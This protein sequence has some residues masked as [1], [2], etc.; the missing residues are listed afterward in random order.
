VVWTVGDDRRT[1]VR[2]NT[3]LMYDQALLASYEQALINDGTNTRAAATFQPL[4]PGAPAFPAVLSAGAGA[5]PNTLTTV[6]RD[7]RVASNWQN[8]VQIERQLTDRLA[9][10]VGGSYAR[11]NN[12]PVISNINLI[13]PTGQLSDGRN[14]Y[15]TAVNA[16]T[17]RDPR[18]NSILEVQSLGESTYRALTAQLTGRNLWGGVQFDLAYTLAKTEDNAPITTVLSVQGDP[19]GRSNPDDLDFD[20][21]PNALD[22]RHTFSGSVV[23]RPTI[24]GGNA[25][26]RAIVNGTVVGLAMQFASGVPIYLRSASEINN[27]G[28]TTADRPVGVGRNA[29]NLPARYNTDLRLSRQVGVGGTRKIEV[30]AE[31][32]NLFNTVQWSGVQ[33]PAIA[34]NAATGVATGPIPTSGDQLIPNAGYEQRQLQIGFRFVF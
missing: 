12:L 2:A 21:G 23:A 19:G 9:A 8:N 11:G 33:N 20:K 15:S 29:I 22:Q 32:K 14:V 1:V 10:A 4:T 7:F 6:S 24:E 31:V 3:G 28:I 27:D 25:F 17:R 26:T 30:I 13:N 34:V 5:T 18:Y 16:T